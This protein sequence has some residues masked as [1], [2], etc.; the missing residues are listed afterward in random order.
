MQVSNRS[1]NQILAEMASQTLVANTSLDTVKV[2]NK[3]SMGIA[4]ADAAANI[5]VLR[6]EYATKL[7]TRVVTIFLSG[8]IS[9]Q[10]T[11]AK[12]AEEEGETLTVDSQAIYKKMATDVEPTI[13][14]QRQFGGTQA[15]HLIR[16]LEEVARA[17]GAE[18]LAVPRL[19]EVMTVNDFDEH[20]RVIRD[21]IRTQVGDDLNRRA[22][23]ARIIDLALEKRYSEKV[24]PV[25]VLGSSPEEAI[26][27]E[28]I[29]TGNGIKVALGP[30]Q[31]VDKE[32]VLSTF[33]QIRKYL[34]STK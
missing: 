17:A 29:F 24:I 4:I 16:S 28:K 9:L 33:T 32:F 12:L 22:I 26:L 23:E 1:L 19:Q 15:N 11:F 25:V 20:V 21:M 10:E 34:K 14:A 30:D 13:G 2:A 27:Q 6:Q 5:K 3:G 8:P 7:S 18:F 31:I